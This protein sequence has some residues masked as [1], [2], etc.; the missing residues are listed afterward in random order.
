MPSM[1]DR[2]TFRPKQRASLRHDTADSDPNH[3]KVTSAAIPK[4]TAWPGACLKDLDQQIVS[5]S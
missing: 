1:P 5:E 3:S 2:Q 4:L